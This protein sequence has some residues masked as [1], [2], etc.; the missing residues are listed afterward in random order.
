MAGRWWH[1]VVGGVAGLVLGVLAGGRGRPEPGRTE[2][3]E[4]KSSAQRMGLRIGE[5]VRG[6]W[7]HRWLRLKR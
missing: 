7:R 1:R 4:Y 2:R 6:V 3:M 5:R